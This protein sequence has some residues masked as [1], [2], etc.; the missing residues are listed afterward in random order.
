MIPKSVLAVVPTA[1]GFARIKKPGVVYLVEDVRA[2]V[3]K[4]GQSRSLRKRVLSFL[5]DIPAVR[6]VGYIS[7][8][9]ATLLERY[10]QN[11]WVAWRL[12]WEWFSPPAERVSWFRT[13]TLVNWSWLPSIEPYPVSI[14]NPVTVRTNNSGCKPVY[15]LRVGEIIT[16]QTPGYKWDRQ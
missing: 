7:T 1:R 3:F 9:Q 6:L 12:H 2:G 14:L 15:T 11:E 13:S 10:I 4:L 16:R 5:R 8:N